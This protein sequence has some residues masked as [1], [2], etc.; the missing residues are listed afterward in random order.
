VSWLK[1]LSFFSVGPFISLT[2]SW[3]SIKVSWQEIEIT[4]SLAFVDAQHVFREERDM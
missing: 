3:I 2:A 1:G 4:H